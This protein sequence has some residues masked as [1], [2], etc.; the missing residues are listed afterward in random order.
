[1]FPGCVP[2][3]TS[4][5]EAAS[6]A[7]AVEELFESA[8]LFPEDTG[9]PMTVRVGPRGHA[10]DA[11]RVKMCQVPGNRM[12]P[13]ETAV[14]GILPE[15]HLVEGT[16]AKPFPDAAAA[17]VALNSAALLQCWNGGIGTG[18]LMRA[19]RRMGQPREAPS[20][21]L[22]APPSILAPHSR[23]AS[24]PGATGPN[25]R[26]REVRRAVRRAA[27]GRTGRASVAFRPRGS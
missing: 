15:P 7:S 26:T 11:A 17:R 1:M 9:L 6:P 19:L 21:A 10:R 4:G 25:M 3:G 16:L 13:E 27:P 22:D 18:G 20:P 23:A 8:N 2:A 24:L 12:V 5:H 14:T